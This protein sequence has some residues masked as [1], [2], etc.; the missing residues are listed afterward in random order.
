[1]KRAG[2][3]ILLH[4]IVCKM[5][6]SLDT[7]LRGR[8]RFHVVHAATDVTVEKK[9][10]FI[11]DVIESLMEGIVTKYTGAES[12]RSLFVLLVHRLL[13][14]IYGDNHRLFSGIVFHVKYQFP[15][16]GISFKTR[17]IC[18]RSRYGWVFMHNSRFK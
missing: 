6:K 16:V 4:I 1:M 13:C 14:N 18:D 2:I 3:Y 11:H 5:V 9:S 12:F 15:P 10:S 17:C 8:L 7:M